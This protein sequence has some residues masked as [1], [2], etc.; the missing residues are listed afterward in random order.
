MEFF[1]NGQNFQWIQRIQKIWKITEAWIGVNFKD[2]VSSI[3]LPDTL[4]AC[5]LHKKWQVQALLL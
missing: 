2:I 1:L 3:C 4:V 5:L